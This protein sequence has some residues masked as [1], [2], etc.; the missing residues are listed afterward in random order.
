MSCIEQI[1]MSTTKVGSRVQDLLIHSTF[2]IQ[3][4]LFDENYISSVSKRKMN[5]D[6]YESQY[7]RDHCGDEDVLCDK[8]VIKIIHFISV[9]L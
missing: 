3:I 7:N 4:C 2:L 8:D 6:L 9:Y 5:C 1:E